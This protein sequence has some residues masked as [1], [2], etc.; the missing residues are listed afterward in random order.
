MP[1]IRPAKEVLYGTT[2]T[3][4]CYDPNG[5]PE[6]PDN[7][8]W[9]KVKVTSGTWTGT[10]GYLSEHW[11]NTPVK[12]NQHVDGEPPCSSPTSTSSSTP[13][14]TASTPL[15]LC[16]HLV[17]S[18]CYGLTTL[19]RRDKKVA[20]RCWQDDSKYAGTVRWFWVSGGG[21]QGFVSANRVSP[22]TKVPWCSNDD[23]VKAVRWAGRHLKEN[24]GVAA[25]GNCQS[26]VYA[27][28]QAAGRNIASGYGTAWNYWKA[29]PRGYARGYDYNP[30]VGALVYWKAEA[31]NAAGH[32]GISVGAGWVI[33]TG[34]REHSGGAPYVHVFKIVDRNKTKPWA[35]YL[36][37][38]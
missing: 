38:P 17:D 27:A 14:I 25:D 37:V 1:T 11:L 7:R 35:G 30:P 10:V 4:I 20:M 31:V 32:V 29:N 23:R 19:E 28:Y 3:L 16:T 24:S 9:D 5:T 15:R 22:Q 26:F 18:S 8:I 34:E 33:S 21:R 6:G 12:A 13:T 36:R 2:V